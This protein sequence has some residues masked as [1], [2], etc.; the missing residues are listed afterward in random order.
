M[1]TTMQNKLR[2]QR[3][4]TLAEVLVAI[5]IL[6]MVTSIVA[7]GIPAARNAYEK[8]VL[9]SN[10]EVLLSTTITSLRNELGTAKDIKTETGSTRITYYNTTRGSTSQLYVNEDTGKIMLQRYYSDEGLSQ[11][12]TAEQLLEKSGSEKLTVSYDEVEY[13][14]GIVTFSNLSVKRDDTPL[15]TREKVSIR[16]L[17]E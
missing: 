7:A 1:K 16:V 17:S 10:A 4:F 14:N 11:G 6:L 13:K 12:S 8:V 5:L 15:T 2:S 3:G 9:S